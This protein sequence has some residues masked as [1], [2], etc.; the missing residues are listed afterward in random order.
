[1]TLDRS[2]YIG[3]SDAPKIAGL[4]KWGS[5][6]SVWMEK[7]GMAEPKRETLRMWLGTKLEP[8]VLELYEQKTGRLPDR[9]V[10]PDDDPIL[11]PD[12][13]FIGAHPDYER[14]ECKTTQ[15]AS[16]WGDD[17]STATVDDMTIPI[18]YFIQTQ[19]QNMVMGWDW[20]DL[21]VLIGHDDFRRYRVP[22]DPKVIE[23]L[24]AVEVALWQ[25]HVLTG[26][27]PDE[28]DPEA[29]KAY[30]RKVFPSANEGT[31]PATPDELTMLDVWRQAKLAAKAAEA[32]LE[33]A[34]DRVKRAI[35]NAAGLTG[36]ATWTE[37][38]GRKYL[39]ES[40]LRER[41]TGIDRLDILDEATKRGAPYRTLRD[42]R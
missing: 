36:E 14:L 22:A 13:S 39:D 28:D 15:Y 10:E 37:T 2:T 6:L 8:I 4:S 27:P 41:L 9:V 20:T 5:P 35:G 16:G 24:L 19:H 23:N 30:L 12:H 38:K 18:D 26:V 1:M 17:M 11:H 7:T 3:S 25:D 40:V 42:K 33:E 32:E 21:A 31:R 29:R 34:A